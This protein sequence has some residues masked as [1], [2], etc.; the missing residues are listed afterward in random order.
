MHMLEMQNE[1]LS[2]LMQLSIIS[3]KKFFKEPKIYNI[4]L[5]SFIVLHKNTLNH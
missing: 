4:K 3:T 5:I 1:I 2:I